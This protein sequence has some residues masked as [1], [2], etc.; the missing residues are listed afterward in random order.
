ML[1]RNK[2]NILKRQKF[3]SSNLTEKLCS[4]DS[5]VHEFF[6]LLRVRYVHLTRRSSARYLVNPTYKSRTSPTHSAVRT[7]GWWVSA[8]TGDFDLI[9][10]HYHSSFSGYKSA[11]GIEDFH[12]WLFD[13]FV[14]C[15]SKEEKN[16][17]QKWKPNILKFLIWNLSSTQNYHVLE[18][19]II[20][21]DL[22]LIINDQAPSK[23]F[24]SIV[25][26][27]KACTSA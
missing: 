23:I 26:N 15:I 27:F 25:S 5:T 11:W 4:F 24:L 2:T 16:K 20:P 19:S 18:Q 7:T 22:S 10:T 3:R 21:W 14:R 8:I 6:I 12:I 9:T 13:V 1:S 17:P